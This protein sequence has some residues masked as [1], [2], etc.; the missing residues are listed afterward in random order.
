MRTDSATLVC[1]AFSALIATVRAMSK[2]IQSDRWRLRDTL[3]AAGVFL[4]TAAIVL[5][6][7]AHV[8]VL[9]DLSYVLDTAARISHGQIP[10]RDFPLAHAPLTFVLHALLIRLAGRVFFFHVLLI[11]SLGGLGTVLTW[12]MML[13][14]LRAALNNNHA[15]AISVTL[16]APLTVLGLYCIFPHPSYDCDAILAVLIAL[17]MMQRLGVQNLDRPTPSAALLAGAASVLPLFFKQ[18]IGLPFLGAT[19]LLVVLLLLLGR[20]T[21]TAPD[22]RSLLLVLIGAGAALAAALLALHLVAGLPNYLHWTLGFAASRRMPGL[23][24]MLSIY[25]GA[26]LVLSLAAIAAGVLLLRGPLTRYG[27]VQT[28]WTRRAA[29]LLLAAP[30]FFPL[31]TLTRTKASD[32][33]GDSL[34][35]LFPLLLVLTGLLLLTRLRTLGHAPALAPLLPLAALAAIHGTLMS[36]QLWGSTYALWPLFFYL[37]TELL[38][39]LMTAPLTRWVGPALAATATAA[40]LVCGA[41]YTASEERLSYIDLSD[42]PPASSAHPALAG[43]A[44]PGPYLADFDELLDYAQAHIDPLDAVVLLPG[45][46]PFYFATGRAPQFPVLLF[47]PATDPYSPAQLM[48]E[49]RQRQVKW[50]VLKHDLQMNSD[51]MPEREATLTRL[52]G[53]YRITARLRAYDVYRRTEAKPTLAEQ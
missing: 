33:R 37:L 43:L 31:F 41:L 13:H 1:V 9:W 35:A 23:A 32:T 12:R 39:W 49:A 47:D 11:A 40:L 34:L 7:N 52:L 14:S 45:E 44:T 21:P 22:R 28:A 8:A 10:Y 27:W 2:L 53:D 5:W 24:T 29:F 6:Q 16:A 51:P 30:F 15:W 50:V 25:S 42:Q 46:D 26:F 17:F 48:A 18:N 38:G 3:A 19:L 4:A 20:F 36:Q